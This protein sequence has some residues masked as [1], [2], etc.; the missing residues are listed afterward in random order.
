MRP[1]LIRIASAAPAGAM[2]MTVAPSISISMALHY[3][4][5]RH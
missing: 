5:L 1:S 3:G 4:F 2:V